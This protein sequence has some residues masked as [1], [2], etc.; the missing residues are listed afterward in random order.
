MT[1]DLRTMKGIV[2]Q[3]LQS[4]VEDEHGADSW[5]A[6][7]ER[8]GAAGVYTSLGSY[9]DAELFAIVEAASQLTGTPVTTLL[10][11]FGVRAAS[12]FASRYP[13]FFEK[14]SE[15]SSFLSSLN[16][17]IHAEVKK[18]YPG[19]EVPSFDFASEGPGHL[20]VVYWSKKQLCALAEGLIE[21][22]ATHF[23]ERV[24]IR[25][26]LC[27]HRGAEACHLDCRFERSA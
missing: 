23:G 18:L 7:L 21:G 8:S 3:L 6:V 20:L 19:A 26:D 15:T 14:H 24:S 13:V 12:M 27:T 5:D 25:H 22:S 9:P 4:A 1:L 2:F 10:R 16:D 17:V 11:W